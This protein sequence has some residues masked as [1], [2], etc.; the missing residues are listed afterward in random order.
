MDCEDSQTMGP[1]PRN[2]FVSPAE[3]WE[4]MYQSFTFSIEE[5][6]YLDYT[7][8]D[9]VYGVDLERCPDTNA[10]TKDDWILFSLDVIDPKI[11]GSYGIPQRHPGTWRAN[12]LKLHG[13]DGVTKGPTE[14]TF[15]RDY[16]EW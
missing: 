16:T 14:V 10:P 5:E 3:E 4:I 8:D 13:A 6:M 2:R 15:W 9:E 11:G 7:L 1:Y 12:V